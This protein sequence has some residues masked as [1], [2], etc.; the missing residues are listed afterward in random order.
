MSNKLQW[1]TV[2]DWIAIALLAYLPGVLRSAFS[3]PR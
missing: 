3:W 2:P 1:G